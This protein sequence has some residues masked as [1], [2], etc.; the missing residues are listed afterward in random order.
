MAACI[1]KEVRTRKRNRSNRLQ[2]KEL[3]MATQHTSSHP[4]SSAAS[5]GAQ[6][7]GGTT[8]QTSS[9]GGPASD[10]V[11]AS[12]QDIV[13][14]IAGEP[15]RTR[16]AIEAMPFMKQYTEQARKN[17]LTAQVASMIQA[18]INQQVQQIT[19]MSPQK[20]GGNGQPSSSTSS[21]ASATPPPP[22]NP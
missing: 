6:G 9:K 22:P 15:E 5:T 11:M 7:A 10:P 12:A 21:S 8:P 17:A 20:N 3:T 13:T 4:S 2:P 18:T 19:G 14:F 1:R 16:S